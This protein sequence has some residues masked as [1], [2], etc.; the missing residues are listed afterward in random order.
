[1]KKKV[2]IVLGHP[3]RSSF[4]AALASA[5]RDGAVEAGAEVRELFL[6][7]LSFDP[8]LRHGYKQI[9]AL[10]PDLVTAQ[11]SI[12]W[13]QHL[14]WVYP[15]W[16]GTMPALLKGFLDRTL[17]PGFAFKYRES[18]PWWDKYLSGRSGR[19]IVTMDSPTL[20]DRLMYFGGGRRTMKKA[21]LEFC[22]V[23]P[24]GVTA[25]GT[26]RASTPERRATWLESVMKLGKRL[27]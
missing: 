6:G 18:S 19:I 20:Y 10:E 21:V 25:F 8:I 14:V 16:W 23:K 9:Q 7:D 5:Y 3:D 22:G 27:I 26:V 1:M 24:V 11:E 4:G 12:K 15:I 2:L 17:L 13:A